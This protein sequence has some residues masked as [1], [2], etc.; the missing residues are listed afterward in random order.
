MG[1][2]KKTQPVEQEQSAVKS[3]LSIGYTGK[4]KLVLKAGKTTIQ[5]KTFNNHGGFALF[6]FLCFCLA[7]Q[8][9]IAENSRPLSVGLYNNTAD[10]PAA[11]TLDTAQPSSLLVS[12]NTAARIIE[13]K[14]NEVCKVVFHFLIPK[15]YITN[16][17]KFNQII[18]YGADISDASTGKNNYSA[19]FNLT[20]GNSWAEVDTA[21]WADNFNLVI[22][23]EMTLSNVSAAAQ[24][25]ANNLMNANS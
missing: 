2:K 6:R 19:I 15:I 1:R 4:V 20:S 18:L 16:T 17:K 7:G 13:D 14:T 12:N 8:Y 22:E 10:T 11:A 3:N 21:Q 23:W 5:T 24:V 25:T 9:S